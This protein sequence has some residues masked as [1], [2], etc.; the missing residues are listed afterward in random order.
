MAAPHDEPRWLELIERCLRR[1][2]ND[3]ALEVELQQDLLETGV[4]NLP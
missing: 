2:A 4:E 1:E 3:P